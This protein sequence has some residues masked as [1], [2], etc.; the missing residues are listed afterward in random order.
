MIQSRLIDL[1]KFNNQFCDAIRH[2]S[3]VQKM[4]LIIM[5]LRGELV[6]KASISFIR[7]TIFL[8]V[9]INTKRPSD[10]KKHTFVAS[11]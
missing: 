7:K 2:L 4:L 1:M 5:T 10:K 8:Q 3:Q 11:D 6:L 9:T